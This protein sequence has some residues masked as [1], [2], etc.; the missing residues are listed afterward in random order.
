MMKSTFFGGDESAPAAHHQEKT[1][2]MITKQQMN[3]SILRNYKVHDTQ[4]KS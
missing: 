1:D 3:L 4:G 2:S